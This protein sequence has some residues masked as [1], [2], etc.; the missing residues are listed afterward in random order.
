[1]YV[2]ASNRCFPNL[3][4][5]ESLIKLAD[6]EYSASEITIGDE[7][8]DLSP[9][10]VLR[11]PDE[12]LRLCIF[13]RSISPTLLFFDVD[14]FD[15]DYFLKFEAS[16]RLAKQIKIVVV[17]VRSAPL[18]TPY[19]EEIERLRRLSAIGIREGIVIGILTERGRISES[20][21]SV[22][23]L[24]K[25]VPELAVTLD[26]SEFIFGREKP[27]DYDSLIPLVCHLRL[28]DTTADAFQ[29]QI[30]QGSLE[31]NKLIVQLNKCRYKGALG[32]NLAPLSGIDPESELRKMRLLLESLI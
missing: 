28:R 21:D 24:A 17:T 4:L 9:E 18:G 26:P 14:P 11:R 29:V 19:N 8:S 2:A 31:Y 30:G 13:S 15:P 32:V 25:S 7:P 23:S 1:M 16:C 3:T 10:M 20:C 27:V 22:R 12:A 6:L 5:A